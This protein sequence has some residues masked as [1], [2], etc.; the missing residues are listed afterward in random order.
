MRDR[1]TSS[2][3]RSTRESWLYSTALFFSFWQRPVED[4]G[5][6][7][8]SGSQMKRGPRVTPI[9]RSD[10]FLTCATKYSIRWMRSE[11]GG[12]SESVCAGRREQEFPCWRCQQG[13]RRLHEDD[14]A[15][16]FLHVARNRLRLR[17]AECRQE[18]SSGARFVRRRI[19]LEAGRR[20]SEA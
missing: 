20:Y 13:M 12:C 7:T 4:P 11:R 14:D 2:C 15:S 8:V 5:V 10:S 18:C 19:R 16:C 1:A 9:P 3:Q 6:S 17:G